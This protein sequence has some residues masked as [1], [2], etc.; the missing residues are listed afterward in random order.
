M[1][2]ATPSSDRIALA[3]DASFSRTSIESVWNEQ[4]RKMTMKIIAGAIAFLFCAVSS[5]LAQSAYTSGSAAGNTAAGYP[6]P[7]GGAGI[8]AYVPNYNHAK[9]RR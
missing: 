1:T 6:S 5:A 2:G 8:Y 4:E 3:V 7:Y 9:R